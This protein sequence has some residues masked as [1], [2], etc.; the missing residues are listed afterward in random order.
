MA[1]A[2]GPLLG[3]YL[4]TAASWRWIFFINLPI[5]VAVVVLGARH[6]PESVDPAASGKLDSA[7]ALAAV[8]FL[9]GITFTFI[10]GPTL[11]WLSPALL[12]MAAVAV[13]GL[14]AFVTRERH[15]ASPMLPLAVFRARQF[16]ATNTV[17]FI[18][19][20][21]L[22]GATFLLP[23]E[24]QVV[25]GYSP[26]ASGAA[27][28]PLTAIMLVLSARSGRLASR[29]GPRLQM[30]VGPVVTGAGFALLTLAAHGSSYVIDV[31]PAVTVFGL[32]LAITV[33]PLTATAMS[34]APAEQAGIASAVNNDVA[35][36]GGLLAVAVLPA[37]SGITGTAYLHPHAL[38][39]GFHTA[40]LIAAALC[41][42]AGLLAAVTITNP[43][44]APS[45]AAPPPQE[46]AHCGLAAPP[47][48]TSALRLPPPSTLG[49]PASFGSHRRHE[50][51]GAA[52][53]CSQALTP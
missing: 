24:L 43:P 2:A 4:I 19:Y 53:G 27:L 17:T 33:A 30:S 31:L 16:A 20:A 49:D 50:P 21:A 10:E 37:L 15:A 32:G 44:R 36:L 14:A 12:T 18:V 7:G 41:A 47:L 38:A 28:L 26:L 13:A 48:R 45:P 29:I 6:V 39:A 23:V 25:W 3:G 42:A 51:A 8:V 11:G 34:S 40:V 5:T 35:R 1:T 22:V 52:D 9:V 46:Y